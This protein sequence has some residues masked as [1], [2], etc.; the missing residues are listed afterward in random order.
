VKCQSEIREL[1]QHSSNFFK[2]ENLENM[3]SEKGHNREF[4]ISKKKLV[5]CLKPISLLNH[6]FKENIHIYENI[7]QG[8]FDICLKSIKD[9][10]KLGKIN[11]QISRAQIETCYNYLLRNKNSSS[12]MI[13]E[14]IESISDKN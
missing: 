4:E 14:I 12:R 7:I 8:S 9:D 5:E 2:L 3:H 10:I 6:N 1:E 13:K 11:E